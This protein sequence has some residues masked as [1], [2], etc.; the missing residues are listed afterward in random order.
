MSTHVTS[1]TMDVKISL[2]SLNHLRATTKYNLSLL[3][4]DSNETST[5][6]SSSP[7]SR[8]C[9]HGFLPEGGGS[10]SDSCTNLSQSGESDTSTSSPSSKGDTKTHEKD[11]TARSEAMTKDQLRKER[12]REAVRRC[13]KRKREAALKLEAQFKFQRRR[14]EVLMNELSKSVK[15][16]E[17]DVGNG[18]MFKSGATDISTT[19]PMSEVDKAMHEQEHSKYPML[20]TALREQLLSAQLASFAQQCQQDPDIHFATS[21]LGMPLPLQNHCPQ[22]SMSSGGVVSFTKDPIMS[23]KLDE[24]SPRSLGDLQSPSTAASIQSNHHLARMMCKEL[25]SHQSESHSQ[26]ITLS[27]EKTQGIPS[28]EA[29]VRSPHTLLLSHNPLASLL[30]VAEQQ[31]Q[32]ISPHEQQM[33]SI[34]NE[35]TVRKKKES[36]NPLKLTEEETKEAKRRE[37]KREAV[38]R[39][40]LRKRQEHERLQQETQKLLQQNEQLQQTLMSNPIKKTKL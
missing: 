34:Q 20:H 18:V 22:G 5:A 39:C 11:M 16:H 6:A 31:L 19:T 3:L 40:R 8:D 26:G 32:F 13:R 28:L 36:S 10:E 1:P 35:T 25:G 4:N 21:F 33:Q 12:K 9:S 15:K 24:L 23:Q 27:L 17:S 30:A 29:P 7:S 14:Q 38:R 37:R 2:P